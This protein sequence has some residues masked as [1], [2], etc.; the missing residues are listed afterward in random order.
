MVLRPLPG[1]FDF[2]AGS[3]SGERNKLDFS[4]SDPK[5]I[6]SDYDSGKAREAGDVN[7][8]GVMKLRGRE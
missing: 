2:G 5:R 1:Q 4:T 3:A 8:D 7:R 6:M